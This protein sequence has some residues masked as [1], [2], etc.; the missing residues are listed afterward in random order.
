MKADDTGCER[1]GKGGGATPLPRDHGGDAENQH[2]KPQRRQQKIDDTAFMRAVGKRFQ[3]RGH[4]RRERDAQAGE[5]GAKGLAN[6]SAHGI[7][8]LPPPDGRPAFFIR[9][10]LR[11]PARRADSFFFPAAKGLPYPAVAPTQL[12]QPFSQGQAASTSRAWRKISLSISN[13]RSDRPTP[14]GMESYR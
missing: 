8:L 11:R 10:F 14:P 3:R 12:G 9:A 13:T 5:H 2:L 4:E 1:H 7:C 6:G